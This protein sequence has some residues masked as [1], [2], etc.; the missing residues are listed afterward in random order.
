M[1]LHAA[2]AYVRRT[3]KL[4]TQTRCNTKSRLRLTTHLMDLPNFVDGSATAVRRQHTWQLA[5]RP[6]AARLTRRT[7]CPRRWS[8]SPAAAS[9]TASPRRVRLRQRRPGRPPSW[10]PALHRSAQLAMQQT[11]PGKG[12]GTSHA[13]SRA[14]N[15]PHEGVRTVN[16]THPSQRQTSRPGSWLAPCSCTASGTDGHNAT[17]TVRWVREGHCTG[18]AGTSTSRWATHPLEKDG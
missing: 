6:A 2:H 15:R 12:G 7:G 8:G 4:A 3:A 10:P 17:H 13:V 11:Q 5:L 18:T 14:A 1:V 16:T 9:A